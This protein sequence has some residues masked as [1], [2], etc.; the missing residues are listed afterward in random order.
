MEPNF[1]ETEIQKALQTRKERETAANDSYVEI[2][3]DMLELIAN[4]NYKSRGKYM[5]KASPL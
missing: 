5:Q 3:P 1:F 4:S 2:N